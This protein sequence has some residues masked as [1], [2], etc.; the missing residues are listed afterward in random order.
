MSRANETGQSLFALSDGVMPKNAGR[1][2]FVGLIFI[3]LVATFAL[4][5]AIPTVGKYWNEYFDSGEENQDTGEGDR[6]EYIDPREDDRGQ[7]K[8]EG[9]VDK[10]NN[11]EKEKREKIKKTARRESRQKKKNTQTEKT[12]GMEIDLGQGAKVE[13]V[14]GKEKEGS[15]EEDK[16]SR[17]DEVKPEENEEVKQEN[18]A[19]NVASTVQSEAAS[20]ESGKKARSRISAWFHPKRKSRFRSRIAS[21]EE[22][23][24]GK[25][26][27]PN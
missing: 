14:K 26:G 27:T 3:L 20:G 6:S 17:K 2:L 23:G 19:P 22:Q 24:D 9:Q 16:Q 18:G 11:G 21:D 12:P 15:D 7:A 13:E 5:M 1:P 4:A 10:K 8:E 25:S